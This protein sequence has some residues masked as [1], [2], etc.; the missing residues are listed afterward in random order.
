M[1]GML[2]VAILARE[3]KIPSL[4]L[5]AANAAEAAVVEGVSVYPV[6]SPL[7]VLDLLNVVVMGV[8]A[9][10]A[11]P[12]VDREACFGELQQF[13]VELKDGRGQQ[14]AQRALEVAAAG[15]HS[16]RMIGPPESGKTMLAK[17]PPLILA[18]LT[19][20]QALETAKIHSGAGVLDSA[21]G[22]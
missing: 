10:R 21:V 16:I 17:R 13:T 11:V 1:P 3:K 7:D 18:R 15:S 4:I 2:P 19:F 12:C 5:P 22:W 8:I 9:A 14:T 20:D 6:A